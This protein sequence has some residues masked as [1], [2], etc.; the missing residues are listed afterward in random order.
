MSRK[1]TAATLALTV[2]GG[3]YLTAGSA[4]AS[5]MGFKLERS[6]AVVRANPT[7]PTTSFLNIYLVAFP[8][9]NGLGDVAETAIGG[10]G[11]TGNKCIGDAG[12]IAAPDGIINVDDAIC[13][14]FTDRGTNGNSF[15]FQTFDP[16]TC[17]FIARG[18]SRNPL[19]GLTFSG[20]TAF[21][22]DDDAGFWITVNG[23]VVPPPANRAVI[24]GSHDPSYTGRVI[25]QP[26]P[27]CTP[28][29]NLIAPP[30]HT[31][32]E[33][34]NEILCGLEGVDWVDTTPAD[35]NPDTCT[36]GIFDGTRN[37]QV[38]TFD[39]IA[40]SSGTDNQFKF[41]G[42]S[43]SVLLGRLAF[44]GPNYDLVP[45]DGYIVSISP[46][47]VTTTFLSPHF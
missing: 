23:T 26:V 46:S 6:F 25:R 21:T 18:A 3:V 44:T 33:F 4:Q 13:D 7:V 11:P 2:A 1:L 35:G 38:G 42:V 9:F 27:D 37:I 45:G 29:L 34:A 30:Y 24:V 15:A 43:F 39:N 16:D 17:R 36:A 8:L 19:T 5:N 40:D 12:S 31:M 28:R 14:L 41:R 22:L 47:H 20:L 32:Y 10:T